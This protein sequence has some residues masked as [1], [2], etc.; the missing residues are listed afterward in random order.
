MLWGKDFRKILSESFN[1]GFI[2]E[3]EGLTNRKEGDPFANSA[4]DIITFIKMEEFSND[5][6]NL[7]QSEIK[8][9]GRIFWNI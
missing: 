1:V 4:G 5:D 8:K 6:P 9:L 2:N 7:L 3:S